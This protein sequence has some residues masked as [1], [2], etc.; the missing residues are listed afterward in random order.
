MREGTHE[1]PH[2]LLVKPGVSELGCKVQGAF[3]GKEV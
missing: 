1:A 2:H 3:L